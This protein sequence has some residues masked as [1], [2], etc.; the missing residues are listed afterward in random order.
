MCRIISV[1]CKNDVFSTQ[2]FIFYDW[3]KLYEIHTC[4][5]GFITE[6]QFIYF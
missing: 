5:Y 4:T 3:I 2:Q 1:V 6:L